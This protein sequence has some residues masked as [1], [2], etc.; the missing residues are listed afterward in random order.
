VQ[1]EFPQRANK[2]L[3]RVR[4][5]RSG[6]LNDPR[7]GSRM[8]GE[9]EVAKAIETLYD[10]TCKK[11]QLNEKNVHLTTRHFLRSGQLSLFQQT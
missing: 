10:M 7:F 1:R 4:D 5:T 9:G 6:N 11:Y 8:T 3:N 2:I